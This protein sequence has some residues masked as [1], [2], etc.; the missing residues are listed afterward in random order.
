MP[1]PGGWRAHSLSRTQLHVTP[2]GRGGQLGP[3]PL[4][5]GTLQGQLNNATRCT[6]PQ[7]VPPS[8]SLCGSPGTALG[9]QNSLRHHPGMAWGWHG[10][11]QGAAFTD[12]RG[13]EYKCMHASCALPVVFNTK[14]QSLAHQFIC[15]DTATI[16]AGLTVKLPSSSKGA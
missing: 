9:A 2:S 15:S 3:P 12:W 11:C 10:P 16:K 1:Q 5:Q 13:R 6:W 7:C 14:E 8:N 4:T